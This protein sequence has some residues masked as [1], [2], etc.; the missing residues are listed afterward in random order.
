M[1]DGLHHEISHLRRVIEKWHLEW[2][3]NNAG[4]G[5]R[6]NF[7]IGAAQ[8]KTKDKPMIEVTITNEEKVNIT[9]NPKTVAGKVAKLDGAPVWS[10]V[11]G[12][13]TVV[14]SAD[15]LSA[16]L[17]SSDTPGDTTFLID[18]DADLGKGVVDVQ[19]TITL[20]V[21]GANAA[22]LGVTVG[23]PVPK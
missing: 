4:S 7:A 8:L 3:E 22:N 20:H 13:S 11:S 21:S 19:D 15:G 2:K 12:D 5:V 9:L 23:T 14:P 18:G 16:D 6:F 1:S 17:V 10:V